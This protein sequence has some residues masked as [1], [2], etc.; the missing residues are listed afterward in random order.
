MRSLLQRLLFFVLLFEGLSK[1]SLPSLLT[2]ITVVIAL[3]ACTHLLL[4]NGA[5]SA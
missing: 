1:L 2:G 5:D 3:T 4:Q